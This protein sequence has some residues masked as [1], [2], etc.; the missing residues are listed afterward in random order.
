MSDR[1]VKYNVWCLEQL[2]YTV[3]YGTESSPPTA[4]T[5]PASHTSRAIDDT[6]T[7]VCTIMD[8]DKQQVIIAEENPPDGAPPTGGTIR[9]IGLTMDMDSGPDVVTEHITSLDI[10]VSVLSYIVYSNDDNVGD[11]MDIVAAKETPIGVLTATA[12]TSDTVLSV[13]STVLQYAVKGYFITL[14]SSPDKDK[15]GYITD[16]DTINSTITVQNPPDTEY[17]A[18]TSVLI[19]RHLFENCYFHNTYPIH[20]GQDKIGGSYVPA[21]TTMH[22]LYTNKTAQ[23]KKL[24]VTVEFLY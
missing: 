15:L 5:D 1:I 17:S 11:C 8:P 3:A 16:I 20:I 4:C 19:T 2:Q 6:K 22:F 18:G 23:A 21:D 14:A 24:W 7:I 9:V 10:D 13:N 12:T